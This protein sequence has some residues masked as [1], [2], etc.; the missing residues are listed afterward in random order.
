MTAYPVPSGRTAEGE[1]TPPPSKSLTHRFL[2]L[3]R[4]S[5]GTVLIENPLQS[6]DTELTVAAVRAT[7]SRVHFSNDGAVVEPGEAPRGLTRID[8]GDAGTLLRF[9][10]AVTSGLSGRWRLD[11]SARLRE[12][13]VG[14]LAEALR[15]LG[16][17]TLWSG[18]EGFAPLEIRGATLQ[19]GRVRLD[20]G[21]SSQFLSALLL[22][23][24]VAPREIR[25]EVD[26][27]TSWPYVD[28]TLD[29]I[30]RFGGRVSV[31][32]NTYRTRPGLTPPERIRVEG[33][34]SSAAYPAAAAVITGGTVS[35][36]GL[37]R[38]SAQGDRRFLEI[39]ER[40]GASVVWSDE[41]VRITG[42]G[43]LTAVDEDMSDMPD[44]VP[45]LAALA[46]FARGT[47]R[48]RAVPHLRLK[49][50][51]RLAAMRAELERVGAAAEETEDG[52]TVTGVWAERQPPEQTV[53]VDPHGDHRIAMSMALVGMR[54]PGLSIARPGVVDKSYPGFWDDIGLLLAP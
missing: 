50:S 27:L 11:G 19:G 25:I 43:P 1:L 30:R 26:S 46:P 3:A 45:T 21:L 34:Y 41:T 36:S 28:L 18:R 29:C 44:Q 35:I 15:Q 33:D 16:A 38:Q 4:L 7:G 13:T 53:T 48:I 32:G 51:D 23:G 47:T 54:R 5:G 40:M 39:L 6:E 37:R 12:R 31:D 20:A 14:P 24:Q 9:L 22:A 42:H 2:I 52:L 8:C 10:T 49:E 17:D